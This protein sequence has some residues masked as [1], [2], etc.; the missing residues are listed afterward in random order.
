MKRLM[1]AALV[2]S[3]LGATAVS[4]QPQHRG[5][6]YHSWHNGGNGAAMVCLGLGLFAL[7]ATA[8]AIATD[9]S[10]RETTK[11]SGNAGALFVS[12]P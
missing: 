12:G 8:T 6:G 4:A 2:L 9:R 3:L 10:G 5:G 11:G 1:S 7:G